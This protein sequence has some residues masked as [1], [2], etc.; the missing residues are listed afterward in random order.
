MV[1]GNGDSVIAKDTLKDQ[2]EFNITIRVITNL[3][4]SFTD[5][6]V[7]QGVLMPITGLVGAFTAGETITGQTSSSTAVISEFHNAHD[8]LTTDPPTGTFTI[9]ETISGNTSSA[10]ATLGTYSAFTVLQAHK[11]LVNIMQGRDPITGLL[12]PNTVLSV[13]RS[14]SQLHSQYYYFSQG[15]KI[16]YKTISSGEYFYVAADMNLTAI[17]DLIARP[18]Y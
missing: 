12:L 2:H 9:G 7:P 6:G 1:F 3:A 14:K 10:T 8:Y 18:G 17:T 16:S 11:Q 15:I 4:A 5:Q 13:I